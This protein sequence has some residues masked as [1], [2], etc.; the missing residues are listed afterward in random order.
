VRLSKIFNFLSSSTYSSL[1]VNFFRFPFEFGEWGRRGNRQE[2]PKPLKT[3]LEDLKFAMDFVGEPQTLIPR[4][5]LL[6]SMYNIY[7]LLEHMKEM[8]KLEKSVHN[9]IKF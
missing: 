1:G 8:K 7:I 3:I 2:Q 4:E 9:Y 5:K 6:E